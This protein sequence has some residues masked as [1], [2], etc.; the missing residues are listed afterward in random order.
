M[1]RCQYQ[2]LEKNLKG[3]GDGG[4]DI[5]L[6][7]AA[8]R[9][10]KELGV[11]SVESPDGEFADV[12]DFWRQKTYPIRSVRICKVDDKPVLKGGRSTSSASNQDEYGGTKI[13]A[14]VFG[15]GKAKKNNSSN[16]ATTVISASDATTVL[17]EV[18]MDAV[19]EGEGDPFRLVERK[20][21]M[22]SLR[23][24]VD[25]SNIRRGVCV[26]QAE[27]SYPPRESMATAHI[28][29]TTVKGS[30]TRGTAPPPATCRVLVGA[31][32][33]HS[34]C[35]LEISTAPAAFT[36]IGGNEGSGSSPPAAA[37]TTIRA[38]GPRDGGELCYRGVLDLRNGSVAAAAGLQVL[39]EEDEAKWPNSMSVVYGD[40][41]RFSWGF[42]DGA[43]ETGYWF[44]KQL[45][46]KGSG[47]GSDKEKR[48]A[49]DEPLGKGWPEPLK[50]FAKM[51]SEECSY[52]HPIQDRPPLKRYTLCMGY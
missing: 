4:A 26:V 8:T 21:V 33:I 32:G 43:H 18:N 2:I 22:S 46:E 19:V 7:P 35:R 39:F 42:I 27:Q 16:L 47:S 40:R 34:L 11:G 24:L 41:I 31:D 45:T 30:D 52:V 13:G 10:L 6:W 48:G 50:T 49:Q 51:T 23:S 14:S 29:E 28:V 5:A 36:N 17:T 15:D 44:V 9:I 1:C 25:E 20:V 38:T 3:E 37:V 12:S